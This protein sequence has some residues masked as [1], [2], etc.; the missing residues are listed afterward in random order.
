MH[1]AHHAS[2]QGIR[3]QSGSIPG[4]AFLPP[5]RA[6]ELGDAL[7]KHVRCRQ[8]STCFCSPRASQLQIFMKRAVC[9]P[10]LLTFQQQDSWIH[11]GR[12]ITLPRRT[13]QVS[14][15]PRS[16][17]V[18]SDTSTVFTVWKHGYDGRDNGT[19]ATPIYT[20]HPVRP[21]TARRVQ[22]EIPRRPFDTQV[23]D[24]TSFVSARAR[25]R[26]MRR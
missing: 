19:F 12:L 4:T 15:V 25:E 3:W 1:R 23:S 11:R 17:F 22:D 2:E 24:A 18:A 16:Q 26:S 10:R 14:R 7:A 9:F 20:G 8:D 5:R 6:S 13:R 21:R